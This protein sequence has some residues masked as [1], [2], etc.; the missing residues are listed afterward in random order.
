MNVEETDA[1]RFLE[2]IHVKTYENKLIEGTFKYIDTTMVLDLAEVAF[3]EQYIDV[4]TEEVT[5]LTLIYS[6]SG[7]LFKIIKPYEEF[8]KI[9][10]DFFDNDSFWFPDARSKPN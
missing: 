4:D 3:Y 2:V 7:L 10:Q 9:H 5:D 1:C 8:K 6:K